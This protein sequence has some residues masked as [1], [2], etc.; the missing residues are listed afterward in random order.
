M[1]LTVKQQRAA[2]LY[3]SGMTVVDVAKEMGIHVVNAHHLLRRAGV[4][5]RRTVNGWQVIRYGAEKK[6]A[7]QIGNM[8][9]L[10]EQLTDKEARFLVQQLSGEDKVVDVI[11]RIVKGAAK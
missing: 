10:L 6:R 1:M 8:Q 7:W 4:K 3:A 2:D 11:A 9:Q 5:R